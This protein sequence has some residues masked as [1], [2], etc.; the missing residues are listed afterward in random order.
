MDFLE[1][2]LEEIIFNTE[3]ESLDKRGLE[4][5]GKRFRQLRIGN[6]GIADMVTVE[7][8]ET[9]FRNISSLRITIFELKKDKIGIAAFLQSVGYMKGIS[10]YLEKRGFSH[11]FFFKIVLVGKCIDD[12]GNFCYLSEFVDSPEYE[13]H[14]S[15]NLIGLQYYTYNYKFNGIYFNHKSGYHLTNPGF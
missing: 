2:D 5:Y 10:A 6:Y 1:K 12:T 8:V 7:K 4:V 11:S 14:L 15:G 13:P 3:S 9:G